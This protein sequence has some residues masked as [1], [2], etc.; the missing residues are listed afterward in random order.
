MRVP[1]YEAERDSPSCHQS[2]SHCRSD[3]RIG[4]QC[5][6]L[7]TTASQ[8]HLSAAWQRRVTV[9]RRKRKLRSH[10]AT[11]F[12][13]AESSSCCSGAGLKVFTRAYLPQWGVE[14]MDHHFHLLTASKGHNGVIAGKRSRLR[15]VGHCKEE[16]KAN[17]DQGTPANPG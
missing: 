6:A 12:A 14:L 3:R 4:R 15:Q 13:T 7:C 10:K 8:R 17:Q 1:L 16:K 5:V 11:A 2:S 9:R